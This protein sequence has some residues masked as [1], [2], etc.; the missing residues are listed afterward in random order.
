MVS[1]QLHALKI[2]YNAFLPCHFLF[3][4][5]KIKIRKYKK[6]IVDSDAV[7][8]TGGCA[9]ATAAATCVS[10]AKYTERWHGVSTCAGIW[11]NNM[12]AEIAAADLPQYNDIRLFTV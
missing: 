7:V 8:W 3:F 9:A 12:T 11:M 10:V 5:K 4:L 6:K 1:A 2:I